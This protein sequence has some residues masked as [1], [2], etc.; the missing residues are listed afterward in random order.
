MFR[1]LP[2]LDVGILRQHTMFEKKQTTQ[3]TSTVVPHVERWVLKKIC[4]SQSPGQCSIV[5][6]VFNGEIHI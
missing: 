1:S 4:G 5:F 2:H 6:I 3:A